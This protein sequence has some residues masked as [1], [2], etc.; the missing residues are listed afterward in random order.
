MRR[1][2]AGRVALVAVCVLTAMFLVLPTLVSI[3]V[4]F[5]ETQAFVFPPQG[6][7]G[8]WYQNFFT[9][10]RWLDALR[11]SLVV[12]ALTTVVA[13]VLGSL[14]ALALDRS[15]FRGKRVVSALLLT[16]AIVPVILLAIGLYWVF[17]RW[18]LV[19]TITG[20]V[21]AHSV[22]GVPLVLRTVAASLAD[23]DRRVEWAAASLGASPFATLRQVTL[24]LISPGILA[25]AIFAFI[26]SFDEVVLTV[27]ISSPDLQTLPVMMFTA[28]TREL[29]PTITA[30]SSM[31][32]VFTTV[33]ILIGLRLGRKDVLTRAF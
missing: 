21:L 27:F 3:P 26:G 28:V 18:E 25:G 15:T 13:T 31:V 29:D 14:G 19:G 20:L 17:L 7:S 12:A 24:P 30:A 10:A 16:P 23:H 4:S 1:P 8:R 32:L 33:L 9:D 22:I 11:N 6:F 5:S 2:R